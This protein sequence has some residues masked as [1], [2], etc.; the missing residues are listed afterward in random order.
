MGEITKNHVFPVE[1]T[2]S[3]FRRIPVLA[4]GEG[5]FVYD[6]DGG[7]YLDAISGIAVTNIGYGRRDVAGAMAKQAEKFPYCIS[8][9]F[10]NEPTLEL[11]RRL[12]EMTPD[13]LNYF[14]FTSGG[15]EANETAFKIA[16]QFH[17][18]NGEPSRSLVISRRQSYHG[19]T[20]GALAATGM[21]KRREKYAPILIDLPHIA[22]AYCYRCPFGKSYP[23]CDID[24]ARDLDAAIRAA[25]PERVMAFVV[26]PVVGSACGATV[27]PPEYFP[28]VREI[29]TRY[30]V[31]LIVDEVITGMGRTGR[32]FGID[33]WDVVPDIMTLA[34]GLSGGYSPL[35]AVAVH[36]RVLEVF[37]KNDGAF[38]HIYTFAG[39][40]V[41]ASAGLAALDILVRENLV[42]RS[43]QMGEYL[44]RCAESLKEHAV[45][46]D[47]R[48]LGLLMGI[49]L[50]KD[51]ASKEPFAPEMRLSK[52]LAGIALQK[53]LIIYPCSGCADGFRGDHFLICPPLIVS[54]AECDTIISVLSDAI[55]ELEAGLPSSR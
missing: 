51:R 27:P 18:E 52:R 12:S 50:V 39:N 3:E 26:E 17:L 32:N 1:M 54:R 15:S 42:S 33:H 20:L 40:P 47:I 49:E 44:F 38:E 22:P 21:E 24:C 13:G 11:A 28:L 41:S 23:G 31:L 43:A 6:T 8:N 45:V 34:K 53:G 16:R 35:G 19:A 2:S 9:L 5:V 29:C 36:E 25:G 14:Q 55:S 10:T 30:G 37:E 4:R 48:G 46:G 7:K